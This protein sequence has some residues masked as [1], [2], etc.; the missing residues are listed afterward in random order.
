[1]KVRENPPTL[2]RLFPR[3]PIWI[4]SSWFLCCCCLFVLLCFV[5]CG[6]FFVFVKI[7]LFLISFLRHIVNGFPLRKVDHDVPC[8]KSTMMSRAKSRPLIVG[9]LG[10]FQFVSQEMS[11]IATNTLYTLCLLT[12]PNSSRQN[13]CRLVYEIWTKI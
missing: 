8:E 5:F 4:T 2:K 6:F 13:P 11:V 10:T 1:M 7:C 3:W 12:Y 9:R